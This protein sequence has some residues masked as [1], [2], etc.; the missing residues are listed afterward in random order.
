ML[1][2][3]VQTPHPEL[4]TAQSPLRELGQCQGCAAAE[5]QVITAQPVRARLS[6]LSRKAILPAAFRSA[7]FLESCSRHFCM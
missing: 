2:F 4:G 5:S 3:F 6:A 1:L 7:I